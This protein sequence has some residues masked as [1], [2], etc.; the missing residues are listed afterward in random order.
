[1]RAKEKEPSTKAKQPI[2][3]RYKKLANGNLSIYLDIF[4]NGKRVY[5]FLKLYLI[6]E[7]SDE[8]KAYNKKQMALVE[9]IKAK[10]IIQL[11]TTAHGLSNQKER[12]KVLLRDYIRAFAETKG[13]STLQNLNSLAYHLEKY[14]SIDIQMGKIDKH[15]ILDFIDYLEGAKIDH[16]QRNKGK[17]LSK[18]SQ[19]MYFKCLKMTLDEAV[20]DDIIEANPVLAVKKKYRPTKEKAPKREYL[21]EEE[22]KQFAAT[23][24]SNDLLKRAFMIGCLTGLR[25]CDI[26]QM[27]WANVGT[28]RNGIECISIV[29]EKTDDAVDIPLNDNIR[30]WL[31]EQNKAK[32]SD[33]VFAG[34]I[35]LGRTN[36]ILPK[37][38]EKAG[39]SKHLTFHISRHTFAVLAIANGIDIYTVSKLLGHQSIAV[40]EIYTEVLD[41]SKKQ[42]ME[43]M[44]KINV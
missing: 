20:A 41:N 37:W 15:F 23:D 3:I 17:T 26:R 29:Q 44:G 35:T 2:R 42:A 36:E 21:T 39:I 8:A 6:P 34:L 30:K 9:T 4:Q 22:L 31:P 33:L 11:N 7:I 10:K 16:T 32:N 12:S 1:M 43:K 24:F 27:T 28:I 40:T 14:Q 19:A 38:A 13:K 5:E 25:H 18:N